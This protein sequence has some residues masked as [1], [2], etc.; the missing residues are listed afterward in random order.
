VSDLPFRVLPAPDE[1]T[2]FFWRS[3]QDGRLRFLRCQSCGYYL[4]PPIPRCPS[5]ASR[6]LAPEA[7]SGRATVHSF[8]VNHQPWTGETDPW[9]IAIVELP[10]QE[11]LRLT[12]NIVGCEPDEV[13]IGQAVEVTFEQRDDIWMP[14]FSPVGA[15]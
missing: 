9:V 8:T 3:G 14:L 4:H 15:R 11:G 13:A 5:C 6:D 1:S 2:E 12:T 7:V 10:E